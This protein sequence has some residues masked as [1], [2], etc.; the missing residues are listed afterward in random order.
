MES[1]GIADKAVRRGWTMHTQS[2]VASI[3]KQFVAVCALIPAARAVLDLDES[4][5]RHLVL[6]EG[7]TP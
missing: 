3:S 4:I 7:N 1:V 6:T 2:Q 5:R